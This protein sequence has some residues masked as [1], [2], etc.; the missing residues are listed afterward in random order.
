MAKFSMDRSF[1]TETVAESRKETVN[2]DGYKFRLQGLPDTYSDADVAKWAA[3]QK[4]NV[5]C[6]APK[7]T[8]E[9]G[10]VLSPRAD[11]TPAACSKVFKD[12]A[13]SGGADNGNGGA[14]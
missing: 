12:H 8:T 11:Y 1:R 6:T 14:Q 5:P 7:E 13:K 2:I 3:A 10:K 4:E 9:S